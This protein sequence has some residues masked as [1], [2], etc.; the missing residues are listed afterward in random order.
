MVKY[1]FTCSKCK[2][3]LGL[4]TLNGKTKVESMS[5]W[6]KCGNCNGIGKLE[7]ETIT[8]KIKKPNEF[9]PKKLNPDEFI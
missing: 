9:K 2:E 3:K 8:V 1:K 6:V 4:F 5:F 7:I